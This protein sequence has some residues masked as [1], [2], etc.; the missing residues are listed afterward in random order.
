MIYIIITYKDRA[1][2]RESYDDGIFFPVKALLKENV[3]S[4]YFAY[5]KT[6]SNLALNHATEKWNKKK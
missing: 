4:L 2:E 1:P 6:D 3:E 5:N